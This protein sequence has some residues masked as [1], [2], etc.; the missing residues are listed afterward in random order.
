MIGAEYQL[1]GNQASYTRTQ[2]INMLTAGAVIETRGYRTG[3]VASRIFLTENPQNDLMI[4]TG[5]ILNGN[6]ITKDGFT[7]LRSRDR[8]SFFIRY[9]DIS[10]I[11]QPDNV[12]YAYPYCQQKV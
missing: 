5:L 7:D 12:K 6:K 1:E 3:K 4:N 8:H 9:A 2:L 11:T 10:R